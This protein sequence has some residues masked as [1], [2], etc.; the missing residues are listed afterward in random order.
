MDP[1]ERVSPSAKCSVV[2]PHEVCGIESPGPC[3]MVVFGASG[4]LAHRKLLPSIYRLFARGHMPDDFAVVGTAMEP[5]DDT[6][7][8]A[9]MRDA[10]KEAAPEDYSDE[11]WARFARNLYYVQGEFA[12]DA[13]YARLKARLPGIEAEHDTH[14]NRIYYMAIPPTVYEQVVKGLGEAGMSSEDGGYTRIVIE[15]PFGRDLESSHRLSAA[16]GVSFTESQIYRMDHYLAK[17]NVQNILMFRFANSIFE[18]VWNRQYVDHVQI[19]VSETLGVEHRAGY[20]EKAGVLRDMFQSHLL[21]LLSLVAM[22]PPSAFEADRVRDEKTK[23]FTS[24]RPI[25]EGRLGQYVVVGQYGAGKMSG[26]AVPAYR[27]EPGVAKDSDT[28]TYAAMMLFVDNWRWSG[29]PFYLRSGKRM[30]RRAAEIAIQF[31]PVPHMMFRGV[32]EETI[33]PNT[34]VLR[35][36]PDEGIDLYFQTKTPD[37]KVCL[38]EVLMDFAYERTVRLDAY[39]RVLIDCMLGD[40]ML[41]VRADGEEKTWEILTPVIERLESVAGTTELPSYPAGSAGP[42]EA[43]A[44]LAREGR[45][46]R[47]L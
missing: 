38:S 10:V 11:K 13:F 1:A 45:R 26:K 37:S 12:D 4:D 8:R 25:P 46:W 14:G 30:P 36:Q 42:A 6:D 32:L 21:Q 33:E 29:V 43:D 19:T 15:K 16:L 47:E 28:P 24:I 18:P 39:E 27:D 3:C 34:L 44:L 22:E 41:F 23:V 5:W 20:Y 17:E 35:V 2:R 7:Y 40:Q 31:K 9:R